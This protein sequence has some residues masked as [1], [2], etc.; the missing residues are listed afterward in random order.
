MYLNEPGAEIPAGLL[1]TRVCYYDDD[2]LPNWFLVSTIWRRSSAMEAFGAP[3]LETM[4]WRH[5]DGMK[6]E[7]FDQPATNYN[8]GSLDHHFELCRIIALTGDPRY[9]ERERE[10][11]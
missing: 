10:D 5:D 1:W 3:Y 6:G 9:Y 2:D 7:W 11:T 4:V 8:R